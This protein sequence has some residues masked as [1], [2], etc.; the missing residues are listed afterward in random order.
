VLANQLVCSTRDQHPQ[1]YFVKSGQVRYF[2]KHFKDLHGVYLIPSDLRST[3]NA[4]TPLREANS[5]SGQVRRGDQ[6]LG[7]GDS[8]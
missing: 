2:L 6:D 3:V 7:A 4:T 1:T 5:S 8:E